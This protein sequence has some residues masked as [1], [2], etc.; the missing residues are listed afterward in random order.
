VREKWISFAPAGAT[1]D[2]AVRYRFPF[3]PSV[4]RQLAVGVGADMAIGTSDWTG[5]YDWSKY[6]FD[7]ELPAKQ[8]VLAAR[9]G[10]VARIGTQFTEISE[11]QGRTTPSTLV[12]VLHGD[13]T[14]A[15]YGHLAEAAVAT[16]TRV[17]AGQELGTARGPRI[18]FG[19]ARN[20][21]GRPK[22]VAIRFDDGTPDGVVPVAGLAYGG[23][24]P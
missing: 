10:E 18:H 12:V 23:K 19:V 2:D 6:S 11:R 17:R 7:F 8:K 9:D 21:D 13:G 3:D 22:S 4:P 1:H 5:H 20:V 14:Y 16:G 15:M 24:R